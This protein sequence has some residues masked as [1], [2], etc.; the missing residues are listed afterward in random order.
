M[1]SNKRIGCFRIRTLWRSGAALALVVTTSGASFASVLFP[2]HL[3]QTYGWVGSP[4]ECTL[5]HT[6]SPGALDN[7]VK[8]FAATLKARGVRAG[9][10][11]SLDAAIAALQGNDTDGD[12]APDIDE[13]TQQGDPNDPLILPGQAT[14]PEPVEY[15]CVGGTI[16]GRTDSSS[17]GAAAAAAFV[18][19][20]LWCSRRQRGHGV[21]ASK[22]A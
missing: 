1:A 10:L 21:V 20:A 18:A 7:A 16:A 4:G 15:G 19:A 6:T 9:D 11:A 12:G 17:G 2:Q 14:A 13:L 5:C 3:I 22:R 8:P